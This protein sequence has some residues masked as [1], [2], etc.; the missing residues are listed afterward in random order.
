MTVLQR[1]DLES[2]SGKK[3]DKYY[4]SSTHNVKFLKLG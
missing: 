3:I 2:T 4:L 1:V